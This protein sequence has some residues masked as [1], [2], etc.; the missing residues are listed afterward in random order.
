MAACLLHSI[1][2]PPVYFTP[3]TACLLTP[4]HLLSACSLHSIYWMPVHSIHYIAGCSHASYTCCL[5][6]CSILIAFSLH[7]INLFSVHEL[8]QDLL[9]LLFPW[10]TSDQN[11]CWSYRLQTKVI[12]GVRLRTKVFDGPDRFQPLY[13]PDQ[14]FRSWHFYLSYYAHH[15]KHNLFTNSFSYQCLLPGTNCSTTQT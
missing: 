10:Q 3:F 8:W 12:V 5:F 7:S 6:A 2:W 4:L 11:T 9:T 1:C 14:H 15:E 13:A